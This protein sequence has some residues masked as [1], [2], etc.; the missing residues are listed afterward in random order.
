MEVGPGGKEHTLDLING[1]LVTANAPTRSNGSNGDGG[2][3]S[4]HGVAAGGDILTT[5]TD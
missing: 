5:L 4:G 2:D 1:L 3:A